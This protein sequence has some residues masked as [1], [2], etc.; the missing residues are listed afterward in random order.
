MTFYIKSCEIR[1]QFQN[2][3]QRMYQKR[4]AMMYTEMFN[5]AIQF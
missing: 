3:I 4:Y 2:F 1:F 5:L